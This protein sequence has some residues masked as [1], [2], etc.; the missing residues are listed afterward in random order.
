VI[1][2]ISYDVTLVRLIGAVQVHSFP[3]SPS[4]AQDVSR[5]LDLVAGLHFAKG[6]L[7]PDNLMDLVLGLQ[8]VVSW[9][10]LVV[11]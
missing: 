2:G 10:L 1:A 9:G 5:S 6:Y 4:R 8:Q 3:P 11:G 7:L